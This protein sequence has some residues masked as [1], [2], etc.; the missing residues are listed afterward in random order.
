[1]RCLFFGGIAVLLLLPSRSPAAFGVTSSGGLYSVDTGAGLVFKVDQSSGD[2]TSIVFNGTEYQAT[3]KNSQIASGLGTAAVTATTYGTN[4]I[5]IAIATSSSNSVVRS[6]THYLMVRNGFN[7]VYMATYVSAEPNVGELRWITR[8]Q[9]SKLTNGP[10]PSDNRG[11]TNA[12]ESTDVFGNAD[13]TT[14]SKYYG[15]TVTHG[16]D[17]AIDLSYCGATGTGIGLW[18]VYDNPRE[19]ASGGPFYRDIQNQC[20]TDQE[21]YNYMNSGHNQTDVWRTNVL[22]G[23]YALVFTTG[24]TP[25]FPIDYSWIESGGLNLTGWVTRT[26][27]G[28]VTGIVSGIPAGFQGVVG[29]ANTNAQYW[30]A[31]S[32]NGTYATLLMKPGD[33]SVTLYKGEL[34][35]TNTSVTVTAAQTNML[36]L[37]SAESAPNYIFKIGEWDGTPSGFLN[38]DKIITM[39]PQDVR[40]ADWGPVTFAVGTDP[41]TNFP[42]AS[43]KMANNPTTVLFN[44][45]P[46]QV[47]ALTL[48][49]GITCAYAGGRPKPS[50]GS[51]TP[52]NPSPS[53]Q[54]S[55]RSLTVG[56]YRGNNWLYTYSVPASGL[57]AGQNTLTLTVISGSGT[58]N[59]PPFLSPGCAYDAVEL[60]I[61][62][63]GPGI[64]TPPSGL[65]ATP[66]NMSQINLRWQD[67]STNEINFMIERSTDNVTFSLIAALSA[68]VT[69]YFDAGLSPGT[70]YHYRVRASNAGGFSAYTGVASASTYQ[71]RFTSIT[72]AT[73]VVI[74]RGTNGPPGSNYYALSS[75]NLMLAPNQW[76]RFQTNQFG[77]GGS[78]TISNSLAPNARF[79]M[80]QVP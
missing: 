40:M 4:Y 34:E 74:L 27:R 16:K 43:W 26:N 30:A 47:T 69:N 56:T 6:L 80:L 17:R 22:H 68:G 36:N 28:A 25:T 54:P 59:D 78:F 42:M 55:S 66:V 9:S 23:P 79:Y 77:A 11:T 67:N 38:A 76:S 58:S 39:H 62:N 3:D 71:P 63:S 49:I 12:I 31:V 64:P 75:S 5:K 44:L 72:Q 50:I 29:F 33:Y 51:W 57:V 70:T 32:S 45:T 2:I 65:T 41:P 10:V 73:G 35:V 8:L 21:I 13:G 14:R 46:A 15:D 7:N 61:P 18:M 48:R 20:G 53:S 1:L 24:A 37:S 52:S 60:D 19:S